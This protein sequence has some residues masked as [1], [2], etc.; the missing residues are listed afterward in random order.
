M[1]ETIDYNENLEPILSQ[2]SK[3][4]AFLTVKSQ[5]RSNTMTIGWG[6][7]GYI[8]GR[9]V[10]IAYVRTSRYT[11]ELLEQA[12]EFTISIP[13]N[14]TSTMKD[15]LMMCGSESGKSVDKFLKCNLNAIE[16]RTIKSP[17]ISECDTHY[18]C[19]VLFKHKIEN[20]MLPQQISTNYYDDEA[21]HIV[22]YGEIVDSY[23]L[24]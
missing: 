17:I 16:G 4:G 24:K 13:T 15:A 21:P 3:S 8:W 12:G 20:A 10:F 19:Q 9:K 6:N 5:N 2:L 7:I 14:P 11:Y 1:Y 22:Y 18:E 23:K